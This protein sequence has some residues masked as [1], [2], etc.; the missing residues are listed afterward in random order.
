MRILLIEDEKEI[1][2]LYQE[3]LSSNGF[4]VA[5]AFDGENGYEIAKKG[6]WDILLL[7][8]MLPSKDGLE[9]L[10]QIH[11]EGLTNSRKVV[12]LSNIENS[13]VSKKSQSLGATKYIIKSEIK[14]SDLIDIVNSL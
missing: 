10:T 7:D 9:I 5:T 3:L 12:I 14:P 8:I 6:D 1:S 4:E 11:S 13:E 2:N